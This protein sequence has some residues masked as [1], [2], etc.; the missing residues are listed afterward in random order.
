MTI[1]GSTVGGVMV[2][3][4]LAVI[5]AVIAGSLFNHIATTDAPGLVIVS[6]L[7]AIAG[8]AV[9]LAAYHAVFPGPPR[10]MMDCRIGRTKPMFV[11]ALTCSLR[12]STLALL[13]DGRQN[14]YPPSPS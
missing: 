6:G 11:Y 8:A 13:M 14:R 1:G 12:P 4:C 10:T 9:L 7:A 3:L 5:G 2:D